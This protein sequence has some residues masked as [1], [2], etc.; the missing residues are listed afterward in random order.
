MNETYAVVLAAGKG[1]RMKSDLPKVLHPVCGKPMVQHIIDRLRAI[2]VSEIV[3]VVG[4]KAEMIQEHVGDSVRY[5]LQEEQLG[6]AHAVMMAKDDL[7]GK[8]GT[9]LI[10]TGD[11]P[12]ITER[13][14]ANLANYHRETGAAATILTSLVDDATGYGRIV[15][16]DTGDVAR[17]VEHKDATEEEK[18]ITEINT[19]MFCFDNELL[20]EAL[21]N[22]STDNVQG[23]YYLPDVIEILKKAGHTISATSTSRVE[24]GFGVNDRIQLSRAEH[25]MRERILELHMNNGVTIIDPSST[26]IGADVVVGRDSKIEPRVHLRGQTI[27]GERC[28]IGPNVD[29]MDFKA[30]ASTKIHNYSMTYDVCKMPYAST[31][32]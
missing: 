28:V 8:P 21:D 22:V 32:S 16:D 9:T 3:T 14:L 1:T 31:T 2:S 23:E 7:A 26:Y 30:E 19:G 17:I 11:T 29:I 27:I 20:F 12:L 15:R 4:H 24:E 13:T 25:M 5:A 18:A 6:T 10:L